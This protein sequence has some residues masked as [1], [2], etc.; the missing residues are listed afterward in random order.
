MSWPARRPT[1]Q[2]R[3]VEREQL[4][5]G[6]GRVGREGDQ[7][8]L[9]ARHE[10]FGDRAS[11]RRPGGEPLARDLHLARGERGRIEEAQ[12]T[13]LRAQRRVFAQ[14]AEDLLDLVDAQA[15]GHV[16]HDL[17]AHRL[18]ARSIAGLGDAAGP[19]LPEREAER[20]HVVLGAGAAGAQPLRRHVVRRSAV[21]R[22][23]GPA[24]AQARALLR[25]AEVQDHRAIVGDHH[26]AG[27]EIAV[28]EPLRVDRREARAG[29]AGDLAKLVGGVAALRLAPAD[30]RV[31]RLPGDVLHHQDRSPGA[32]RQVVDAADVRVADRAREQQL[33]TQRFVV[34]RHARLFAHDFQRDRLLGAAVVGEEHLAHAA[35]AEALA[36]LVAVVDD[37]AVP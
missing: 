16:E 19:H 33:L 27:L 2:H 18:R 36:D 32:G 13:R 20:V 22:R 6:F 1:R 3:L 24:R 12:V 4:A 21:G 37:R 25:E 14:A 23:A 17:R 28:H 29:F 8:R 26:V 30:V 35:L 34:A 5:G 31:Q 10:G 7:Q 11:E 15:R 9:R